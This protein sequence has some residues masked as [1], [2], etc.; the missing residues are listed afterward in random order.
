MKNFGR[1]IL[2]ISF[3]V[4]VPFATYFV[5]GASNTLVK[6]PQEKVIYNLPYPG[7]LP[8]SPLYI[9]K[10]IRDQIADFLTRDN[11]KK[12]ELYLL[13]SDKGASMSLALASKGKSQLA[14]DTF[15]ETEKYFLKIPALLKSAKKQGSSAPSS[16]TETL[17]LSNAKHEELI[18]ELMKT[19]PQGLNE[20]LTKLSNLNQQIKTEIQSI[21]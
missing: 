2:L 10:V 15:I 17:K 13:Y 8:D 16:F 1:Y 11:L 19:L 3:I 12:A 18:E 5:L 20:S 7:L 4:I 9:T 6:S 14:I 21:P